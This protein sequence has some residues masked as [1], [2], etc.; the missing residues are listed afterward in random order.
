MDGTTM[1]VLAAGAGL[2]LAHAFDADHV[3]AVSSL[4][5]RRGKG[6]NGPAYALKWAVGHGVALLGVGGATL[7]LGARVPDRLF[8]WAEK[9]IGVILLAVGLSILW[10]LWRRRLALRWHRHGPIEHVHLVAEARPVADHRHAPVLVGL[11]HGFAGSAPALAMLPATR[12]DPLVGMAYLVVFSVGVS[13]GMLVVGLLLGSLQG[14]ASRARAGVHEIGRFV[15]G[16]GAAAI[17]VVWL[18]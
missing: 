16:A 4:A 5:E 2:G 7:L 13:I 11:V 10:S 9:G 14:L 15:L 3:A 12:S 17:G 18:A 8:V 6:V 1:A